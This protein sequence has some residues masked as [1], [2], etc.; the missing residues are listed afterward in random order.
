MILFTRIL[1]LIAA[2]MVALQIVAIA[3][4]H[5]IG[6]LLFVTVAF[7]LITWGSNWFTRDSTRRGF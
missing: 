5:E 1:D 3:L 2:A 6:V 7:A 4:G